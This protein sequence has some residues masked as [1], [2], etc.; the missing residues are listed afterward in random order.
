MFYMGEGFKELMRITKTLTF[1]EYSRLMDKWLDVI[2]SAHNDEAKERLEG[3]RNDFQLKW[4]EGW[5][6][7][8]KKQ[9]TTEAQEE[10]YELLD[11]AVHN[12]TSGSAVTSVPTKE[13]AD[14]IDEIIW[15]EI[16]HFMLDAPEIYEDEDGDWTI[17]CMFGGCYIPGWDG[18]EEYY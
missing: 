5:L 13:L 9:I 10:I 15:G 14:E 16:G 7:D 12:S 11:Y 1:D 8:Y 3:R 18:W 4:M 6:E 2:R 17:D